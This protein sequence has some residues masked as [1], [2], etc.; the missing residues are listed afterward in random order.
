MIIISDPILNQILE[1]LKQM[2]TR[3]GTLEKDIKQVKTNTEDI[4]LIKQAVLETLEMAKRNDTSQ[5]S[6]ER[7]VS[8]DLNTHEH[9]IDIL[10]RRQ[11]KLE[12]DMES[13]KNR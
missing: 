2:N 3:I 5:K 12:A 1:E 6:F 7:K 8:A 10:N 11:L 4:P 9:S 13:L